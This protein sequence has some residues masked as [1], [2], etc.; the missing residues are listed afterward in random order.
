MH[1]L[2]AFIATLTHPCHDGVFLEIIK[3]ATDKAVSW[4]EFV[5]KELKGQLTIHSLDPEREFPEFHGERI[6]INT[7]DASLHDISL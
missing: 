7:I 2:V 1:S 5:V 6:N 4:L 3:P